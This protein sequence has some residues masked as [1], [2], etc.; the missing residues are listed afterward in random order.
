MLHLREDV[1][2]L[3][4]HTCTQAKVRKMEEPHSPITSNDNRS[5]EKKHH[6]ISQ[7]T[8]TLQALINSRNDIDISEAKKVSRG[9][10]GSVD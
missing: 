8:T 5:D 1:D 4:S 7:L 2:N 6:D 10:E 3:R 9:C